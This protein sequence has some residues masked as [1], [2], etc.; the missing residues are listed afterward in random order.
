MW[1]IKSKVQKQRENLTLYRR[2][3]DDI[4]IEADSKIQIDNLQILMNDLHPNITFTVEH[5]ASERT[6]GKRAQQSAIA[7]DR[8]SY[9]RFDADGANKESTC[10]A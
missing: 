10:T 4:F 3:D 5:E 6:C 8:S 9:E 7:V 1:Y 2:Y